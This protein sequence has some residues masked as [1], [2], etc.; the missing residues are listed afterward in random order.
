MNREIKFRGIPINKKDRDGFGY[1]VGKPIDT[2]VYGDLEIDHNYGGG[3]KYYISMEV[4]GSLSYRQRI[5]VKP[6]TVG[7]FTGLK[8]KN[9]VEIYEGDVVIQCIEVK[10]P[11]THKSYKTPRFKERMGIVEF[12]DGC[13]DFKSE[14]YS[15]QIRCYMGY[16]KNKIQIE[17]I[18][19]IHDK[20]YRNEQTKKD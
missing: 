7:Q 14:N 18:G 11:R 13:F 19:N 8:D 6:E 16:D 1:E 12:K 20:E 15:G 3:T 17:V 4:F 5:E 2:F 9:G 10:N